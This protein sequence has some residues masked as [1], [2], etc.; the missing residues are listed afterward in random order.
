MV[1]VNFIQG[2]SM[3]QWFSCTTEFEIQILQFGATGH[4][5]EIT[6]WKNFDAGKSSDN[7]K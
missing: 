1:I 5:L 7:L 4:I 2:Y 3:S 6:Y